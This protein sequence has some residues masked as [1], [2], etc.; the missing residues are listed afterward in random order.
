MG[1]DEKRSGT[2]GIPMQYLAGWRRWFGLSQRELAAAAGM[3]VDVVRGL[4][5]RERGAHPTTVKRLAD[6]LGLSRVVLLHLPP[7]QAREDDWRSAPR[8]PASA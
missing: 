1:T 2:T 8:I 6:A 7:E 4:E 5:R 3:H